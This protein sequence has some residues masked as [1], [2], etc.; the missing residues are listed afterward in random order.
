MM[1]VYS[2]L[3]IMDRHEFVNYA[4]VFFDQKNTLSWIYRA[5]FIVMCY[6]MVV[7]AYQVIY[8]TQHLKFQ[9]LLLLEHGKLHPQYYIRLGSSCLVACTTFSALILS[10]Q[11][12]ENQVP[13]N[14]CKNDI[15]LMALNEICWYTFNESNKRCYYMMILNA[16]KPIK[17]KF[18]ENYSINF[19][20]GLAVILTTLTILFKGKIVANIKAEIP[21]W[22]ID[23][24][25]EKVHSRIRNHKN[26]LSWIYRSTYPL[27]CY[28]MIVPSYQLIY[29]TQ[30]IKFQLM[31]LLEH[32]AA[33]TAFK[34][35]RNLEELF[36]DEDYQKQIHEKIKFC[37]KRHTDFIVIHK[38]KLPEM[39][40]LIVAFS[41]CG[42]LLLIGIALFLSSGK[43]ISEN[44]TRIGTAT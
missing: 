27:T 9:L 31:L 40:N 12:V 16:S 21:M 38:N 4:P 11:S 15:A 28:V 25:G 13:V 42:C 41:L 6:V 35:E 43:I 19:K 44:Y 39:S 30:H 1:T 32:V 5:T 36:Y 7:H 24:A 3:F 8:Y 17:I 22:T 33:V 26:I 29:Y 18:S 23:S 14:V 20:L 37:V 10:G 34:E 2:F